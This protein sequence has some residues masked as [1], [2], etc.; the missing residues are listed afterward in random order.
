MRALILCVVLAIIA[1]GVYLTTGWFSVHPENPNVSAKGA[2]L[3][4]IKLPETYSANA[5]IGKVAFEAKCA[6][7][8][9]DNAAGLD[10]VAP[11]LVH[12]I[13]EP[14]HHGDEAFQRA[15]EL[16]VRGHHWPFGDMPPVA[17]V[18]RGDV[19]MIVAY[20]RELQGEN[21]IQ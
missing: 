14:S 16:G 17:G 2:A 4:Q 10:G 1:V 19:A 15:A 18:T 7:C 11:P 8:H 3:V 13:Y 12:V 6:S 9:G 21:G 5:K 20:I